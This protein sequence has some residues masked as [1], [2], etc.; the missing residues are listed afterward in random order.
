MKKRIPDEQFRKP[1]K[2]VNE[3]RE[4]KTKKIYEDRVPRKVN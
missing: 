3:G 4:D 2:L 1:V